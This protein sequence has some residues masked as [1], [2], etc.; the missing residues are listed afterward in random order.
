MVDFRTAQQR[1]TCFIPHH[2]LLCKANRSK[3]SRAVNGSELLT[4]DIPVEGAKPDPHEFVMLTL[5]RL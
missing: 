4:T 5:E 2:E 3:W 1:S